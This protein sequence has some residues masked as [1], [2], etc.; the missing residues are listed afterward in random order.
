[1]SGRGGGWVAAQVV[2]L[3]AFAVVAPQ[4]RGDAQDLSRGA[5]VALIALGVI[6]ALW[7]AMKLGRALTPFPKPVEDGRLC[8]EGPYRWIRHPIY[9]G[10]LL[11]AAG[12]AAWWQSAAAA[13]LLPLVFAFFAL[14]AR[15]EERWLRAAWPEY[16][17]YARETKAIVPFLY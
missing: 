5:G 3:G 2:V 17:D 13:L 1:M 8:R 15:A 10:V 4:T 11:M 14:K 16:R 9:A 12:W 6:V 7:A